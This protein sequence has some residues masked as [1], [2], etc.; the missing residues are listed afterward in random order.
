M[1]GWSRLILVR[2]VHKDCKLNMPAFTPN[3][4]SSS[5]AAD[6]G[7]ESSSELSMGSKPATPM[8]KFLGVSLPRESMLNEQGSSD[9]IGE[10]AELDAPTGGPQ[11]SDGKTQKTVGQVRAARKKSSLRAY[12]F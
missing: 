8:A 9:E 2:G 3:A 6:V 1:V 10:D 7:V 11:D 4:C 12:F 5:G